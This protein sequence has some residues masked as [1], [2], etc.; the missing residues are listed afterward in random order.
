MISMWIISL[1]GV[2]V[3]TNYLCI[4][5]SNFVIIVTW[6]VLSVLI[7]CSYVIDLEWAPVYR[8][9][10]L[11]KR[12]VIIKGLMTDLFPNYLKK[13]NEIVEASGGPFLLGADYS[14]ADFFLANYLEIFEEFMTPNLLDNYAGLK[15]QKEAVFG[16]PQ[17][18]EYVAKRPATLL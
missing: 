10:D 11:E 4:Q 14:W 15:K 2:L 1:I 18:K 7:S 16:I 17:I 5:F 9:A 12:Q 3:S 13:F 8:E 6:L